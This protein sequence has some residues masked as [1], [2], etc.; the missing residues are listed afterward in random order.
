MAD[1]QFEIFMPAPSKYFITYSQTQLK[2]LS[3]S[4]HNHHFDEFLLDITCSISINACTGPWS[5]MRLEC[6]HH[7]SP[8]QAQ[9]YVEKI[10]RALLQ[11]RVKSE[12]R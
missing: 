2:K 1:F 7:L 12:E 4:K 10:I 5:E 6:L 3:I 11:C 9:L 8:G